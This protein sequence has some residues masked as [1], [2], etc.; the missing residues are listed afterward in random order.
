MALTFSL[1]DNNAS[2]TYDFLTGA[3]NPMDRT[4]TP[5]GDGWV[6]ET[7]TLRA[8]GTDATIIAAVNTIDELAEL[9]ELYWE[10]DTR[11][12]CIWL[13]EYSASETAKRSLV[14]SIEIVPIT[15]GK[16]SPLLGNTG[17]FYA[18]TIIRSAA[19]ENTTYISKSVA[20]LGAYGYVTEIAAIDGSL[21]ARISS[22]GFQGD[23]DAPGTVTTIWGGIKP[24][25]DST[26]SSDFQCNLEL[27]T[28]TLAGGAVLASDSD[29]AWPWTTTDNIV[30]YAATTDDVKI[31]YM[32]LYDALG[33]VQYSHFV[34][35]FQVLLRCKSSTTDTIVA[36]IDTGYQGGTFFITGPDQYISSTDYMLYE[37]GEVKIPPLSRYPDPSYLL[38]YFEFQLY[39]R[40]LS[41]TPTFTVDDIVLIPSSHYF[42]FTNAKLEPNG[43]SWA[44]GWINPDYSLG[45]V[46]KNTAG[47]VNMAMQFAPNDW[48]VPIGGGILVVAAQEATS[49]NILDSFGVEL[50]Y[51]ERFRTHGE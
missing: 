43:Y 51:Y 46:N 34:G 35:N 47:K 39:C 23:T 16:F 14:Q 33:A 9:C 5:N 11:D 50:I 37:M 10:D 27:E 15:Q 17:A 8:L 32:T 44:T 30:T 45:A 19:W 49:A 38:E 42:K 6:T 7:M 13:K 3:L 12:N 28:G 40:T 26:G 24:H 31:I 1:A 20:N 48:T 2:T 25:W 36:H 18:I 4:T 21:P 22:I 41:G 29:T